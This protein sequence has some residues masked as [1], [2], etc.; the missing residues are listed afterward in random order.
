MR[1][2]T[3]RF[4]YKSLYGRFER[5]I[6]RRLAYAIWMEDEVMVEDALKNGANPNAK[7]FDGKPIAAIALTVERKHCMPALLAAGL[8]VEDLSKWK[9][10][11]HSVASEGHPALLAWCIGIGVDVNA[12]DSQGMTA[13]M[14]AAQFGDEECCKLLLDAG[15]SPGLKCPD[16]KTAS[17]YAEGMC[18]TENAEIIRA[19]VKRRGGNGK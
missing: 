16:K 14:Y 5:K 18:M 19:A 7:D 4:F 1:L 12:R 2:K 3:L 11:I 15:A 6:D 8:Q 10:L 9:T 17:D 13:L